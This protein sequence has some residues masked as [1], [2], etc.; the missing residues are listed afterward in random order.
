MLGH[1][2][3]QKH[4]S[5]VGKHSLRCGKARA[6]SEDPVPETRLGL[7]GSQLLGNAGIAGS[8][9]IA[10]LGPKVWAYLE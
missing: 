10:E 2:E 1:R 9:R 7:W 5:G 4:S 6:V 8:L 3:V